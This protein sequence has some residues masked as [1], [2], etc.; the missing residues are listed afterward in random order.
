VADGTVAEI[1]A[2]SGSRNLEDVFL[3]L[4]ADRA[5]EENS[6]TPAEGAAR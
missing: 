6:P 3:A 5:A 1:K 4:T 2:L